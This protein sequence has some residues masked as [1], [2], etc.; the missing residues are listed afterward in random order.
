MKF[1]F[2]LYKV[3]VPVIILLV[4][5]PGEM[6][7]ISGSVPLPPKPIDRLQSSHTETV[8]NIFAVNVDSK[9]VRLSQKG[10][11]GRFFSRIGTKV[12]A[13]TKQDPQRPSKGSG[14][15]MAVAAL[16]LGIIGIPSL[17]FLVPSVLAIIFGAISLK[18]YKEG[19]H[20]AKGMAMAGLILGIVGASLFVTWFLFTW[21][22]WLW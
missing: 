18:R 3:F 20:D 6:A 15:G 21:V 2:S 17:F 7:A 9:A 4:L 12:S 13:L 1:L 8:D 19:Y 16:V 10:R 11:I 5:A 14:Y 22:F